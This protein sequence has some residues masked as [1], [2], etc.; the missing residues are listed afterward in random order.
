MISSKWLR[1]LSTIFYII[2]KNKASRN[3]K[4]F[5]AMGVLLRENITNSF[6][7][8]H[9]ERGVYFVVIQTNRTTSVHK[10]IKQ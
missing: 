6:S 7:L 5:N 9:F 4:I 10:I 3:I 8:E 2:L 1:L